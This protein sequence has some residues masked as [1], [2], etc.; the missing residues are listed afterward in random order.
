MRQPSLVNRR[1]ARGAPHVEFRW[2]RQSI[3]VR[4]NCRLGQKI[5][6]FGVHL[7]RINGMPAGSGSNGHRL[8]IRNHDESS[9]P[10][11]FLSQTR[12]QGEREA[13]QAADIEADVTSVALRCG[14]SHRAASRRYTAGLRGIPARHFASRSRNIRIYGIFGAIRGTCARLRSRRRAGAVYGRT[15]GAAASGMPAMTTVLAQSGS[16][17]E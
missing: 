15:Q 13:L 10:G 2:P 12:L 14:F 4:A 3:S 8:R 1:T 7:R 17:F 5:A 9:T 16:Q 6:V 11:T